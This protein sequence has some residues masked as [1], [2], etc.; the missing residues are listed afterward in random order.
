MSTCIT[1]FVPKPTD[2]NFHET[3]I[4]IRLKS[5]YPNCRKSLAPQRPFKHVN[6]WSYNITTNCSQ[7]ASWPLR[8]AKCHW[9][10]A[11]LK[12]RPGRWRSRPDTTHKHI[13]P[14]DTDLLRQ[15]VVLPPVWVHFTIKPYSQNSLLV[16]V[17]HLPG[18][19]R[20]AISEIIYH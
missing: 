3:M 12:Q 15:P 8:Q 9:S 20:A 2:Y 13:P 6:I 19:P 5:M 16:A 7:T 1:Q 17:I 4:Y 10:R 18:I 14:A 11:R